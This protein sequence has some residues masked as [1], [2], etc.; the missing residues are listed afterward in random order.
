MYQSNTNLSAGNLQSWWKR[1]GQLLSLGCIVNNQG[2]QVLGTSDLELRLL[3]G[4]ALSVQLVVDLN[5]SLL[6]VSSSGKLNK[7]LDI[8]YFSLYKIA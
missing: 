3:E 7:L 8:S 1:L 2:V 4:S 6:D 5:G